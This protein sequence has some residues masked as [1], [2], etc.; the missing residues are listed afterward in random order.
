[1]TS[2]GLIFY[3]YPTSYDATNLYLVAS[4]GGLTGLA[5]IQIGGSGGGGLPGS[6]FRYDGNVRDVIGDSLN[7][8]SIAVMTQPANTT[9]FP[10]SPLATIYSGPNSTSPN[11]TGA[12]WLAGTATVILN[13]IPID[14]IVGSYVEFDSISPSG[15]NGIVQVTGVNGL[16][17]TYALNVNP[18][19]Y[20]SGGTARTS[21]LPNPFLSDNIGN[22][23]FYASAELYTVQLYG[24]TLRQPLV[25]PDQ[26][27]TSGGSGVVSVGLEGDGVVYNPSV[28]GSP[29]TNI[30]VLAPSLASNSDNKFL[31]SPVDGSNGPWVAR[32]IAAADITG[33]TG[34][35]TLTSTSANNCVPL[36]TTVVT[37]PTSTPAIGFT[38]S[39]AAQNTALMGPTG[40]AGAPTYRQVTPADTTTPPL[41]TVGVCF[42]G[43][44]NGNNAV[45]APSWRAPFACTVT[46]VRGYMVGGNNCSVNAQKNGSN[47]VSTLLITA[48]GAWHDA[49][50]ITAGTVAAGDTITPVL[51]SQNNNTAS[52]TV[53]I[54]FTRP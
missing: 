48:A 47:L 34:S 8:V 7:G 13:T 16:N 42:L 27:I 23:F 15:Y 29:V 49:G 37:A 20:V 39:N 1:M 22:F 38:L 31:A 51:V 32:P 17:V 21:A 30:G 19:V 5:E 6:A 33:L 28:T 50:A 12:S 53:Q 44:T 52:V 36:F 2:P 35:G 18:G 41:P 43:P 3:Q 10:G 54:D 9:T 45:A 24:G 26:A 4:A 40:G 11:V 46:N 25:L 14:L